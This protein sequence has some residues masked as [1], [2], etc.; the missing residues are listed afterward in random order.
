MYIE[1]EVKGSLISCMCNVYT[2]LP[3]KS[4]SSKWTVITV[5]RAQCANSSRCFSLLGVLHV[6]TQQWSDGWIVALLLHPVS[7]TT[8]LTQATVFSWSSGH[9]RTWQPLCALL[10]YRWIWHR[11]RH[12][13][14]FFSVTLSRNISLV[15]IILLTVPMDIYTSTLSP[16]LDI[17]AGCYLLVIGEW[18]AVRNLE[19]VIAISCYT[20]YIVN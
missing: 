8:P 17:G 19:L 11:Q 13:F 6:I 16:A 15:F 5:I 3:N 18:K 9:R 2:W 12:F 4:D 1:S 20:T 10:E 14:D 7:L